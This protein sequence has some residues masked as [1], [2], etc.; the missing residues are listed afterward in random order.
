MI[1]PLRNILFN[2]NFA[3][4][5]RGINLNAGSTLGFPIG[6]NYLVPWDKGT[7]VP[8]LS[9]DKG[10]MGQKSIHCPG[11]TGQAQ[12]LDTEWAGTGF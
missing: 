11:T 9:P 5:N 12:N 4:Y 1:R 7:E 8:S 10:T 3:S 6:H 2:S